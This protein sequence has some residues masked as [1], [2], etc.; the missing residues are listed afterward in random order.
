MNL[1][2]CASASSL[3]DTLD[4]EAGKTESSDGVLNAGEAGGGAIDENSAAV[5]DINNHANLAK[6][7][8]EV[9]ISNTTRLDEV[10]EHL[11]KLSIRQ[12]VATYHFFECNFILNNNE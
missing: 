6:V 11:K 1:L 10:L 7:L 5:N 3:K 8:S 4:L 2:E 9:D 12:N